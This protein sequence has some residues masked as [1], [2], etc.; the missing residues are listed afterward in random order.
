MAESPTDG[1]EPTPGADSAL[2]D[3][4]ID[5][6]ADEQH[7]ADSSDNSQDSDHSDSAADAS[8]DDGSSDDDGLVRFAK[9]QGIDDL[10]ALSDREKQLLKV[11]HDNVKEYRNKPKD[12]GEALRRA[13]QDA[14]SVSDEELEDEDPAVAEAKLARAEMAQLRAENRVNDFYKKNPDAVDYQDDMR[15]ILVRT[16]E[17]DGKEA[18]RYLTSDMSRLLALA[19]YERGDT[20]DAA[21]EQGR[22]AEREEL[23]RRQEAGA[24]TAR[25]ASQSTRQSVKIDKNWVAN[26][27]DP[28]N[29]EHIALLDA[30]LASGGLK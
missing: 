25:A 20:G 1:I 7:D 9:S 2:P 23:R 21:R 11:A 14:H 10:S 15:D 13:A 16:I 3:D 22:R 19:K 29:Q 8:T 12:D 17:T 24:G 27:Y 30:A 6:S 18:A 28:T 5:H 4:S 26:T